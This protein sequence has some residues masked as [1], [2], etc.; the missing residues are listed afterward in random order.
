MNPA[1]SVLPWQDELW[2]Q[3][4]DSL[5]KG[6]LGHAQLLS[7]PQG[8]GKRQFARRMAASLLCEQRQPSGDACGQCRGCQQY[9]A[10][11]H[12]NLFWLQRELNDKGD[13]EKRDISMD[14]L[15]EMMEKLSLSGH[16][17]QAKA[18]V[19]DPVDALNISGANAVLKTVEEPPPNTFIILLSERPMALVATLR[20]RCQRI[21]FSVPD[22][23]LATA[24]LKAEAPDIN[25]QASLMVAGGAP[26]LALENHR[27][28]AGQQI[29]AW[30]SQL[31]SVA[32]RR[33]EP[34]AAAAAVGKDDVSHWLRQF[35]SVLHLLMRARAGNAINSSINRLALRL[36]QAHIE[37]LL[38]E[39]TD[40]QR[41]LQSNAN[42]QMLVESLMISW[43]HRSAPNRQ[44]G[45]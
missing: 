35:A 23:D 15:R 10:S 11:S 13:K 1:F 31:L 43:W 21:N 8:V 17:G 12:P 9:A 5:A 4:S 42:P 24:W 19:V 38:A 25:P 26:L 32:E 45:R 28:G 40:S 3:F 27:S 30:Q 33:T 34:L 7:G 37:R 41:R 44:Q 6:R 36:D 16:Y 14:Q 22:A 2:S 39:V 29:E 20:S 18:V